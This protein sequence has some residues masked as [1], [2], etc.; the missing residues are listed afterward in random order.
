MRLRRKDPATRNRKPSK[1]SRVTAAEQR[2]ALAQERAQQFANTQKTLAMPPF[3]ATDRQYQ[4]AAG[5]W[6]FYE[7]MLRE[8]NFWQPQF[9]APFAG[10]C[11]YYDEFI[12][13]DREVKKNGWGVQGKSTSGGKR[14]WTNPAVAVRDHAYSRVLELST[15]FG[16]TTLD[17]SKLERESAAAA[18]SRMPTADRTEL[19]LEGAEA[20]PP[21]PSGPAG[22][23][24]LSAFDTAPPPSRRPN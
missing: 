12:A 22:P 23:G 15:R 18:S 1:P 24:A 2:A 10:F 3:M 7:P 4:G 11:I 8:R 9:V 21:Q 16:F 6:R 13:A 5:V 20:A 19:P 14:Y 17:L